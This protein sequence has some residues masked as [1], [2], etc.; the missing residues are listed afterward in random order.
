MECKKKASTIWFEVLSSV[1]GV[2][3]MVETKNICSCPPT[4]DVENRKA[5][6]E[7]NCS[8]F[9]HGDL[10]MV[11]SNIFALGLLHSTLKVGGK[12]QK[13]CLDHALSF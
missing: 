10:G 13:N 7:K 9:F 12:E 8:N 4:F 11:E 6:A 2:L 1:L 5:S 3:G